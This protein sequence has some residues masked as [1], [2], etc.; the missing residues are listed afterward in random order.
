M[1]AQRFIVSADSHIIEPYD[2]WTKTLGKKHGDKVPQRVK[3]ARSQKG[4]IVKGDFVFTGHD[5]LGIGDL[6]QENAGDTLDSTAPVPTDDLPPELV[7]RVKRS[8]SD[9]AVRLAIQDYD[10]VAAEVIQGTN[11]LLAMRIRETAVLQDVAAVANDF[12]AD[13][14][15]LNPKRLIGTVMIPLR[16]VDWACKELVRNAKRGMRAAIINADMPAGF[17]PYRKSMYDKFWATAVE[18]DMVVVLHLG[19]GETVDPFCLVTPEE[20]EDGPKLFLDIFDD[21][22]RTLVNEF[23]FGGIFDR[24]PKLRVMLGE[25]ECSWFPYFIYRCRQMSGALGLAMR[26]PRVQRLADDYLRDNVWV[27]FTDDQYVGRTWDVAGEDKLMW[28]SD[29]P[30]PRNTFPNSRTIIDRI[31][32]DMPAHVK[33]NV[34]GL[35]CARLF[36]IDVPKLRA[37]AE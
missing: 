10:G 18:H 23:M 36:G 30:H 26:L 32:K 7:D 3:E 22:K 19:T 21:H 16:N 12:V 27:G 34:E 25:Y 33:A 6:R 31:C 17:P 2:L 29:Y 4:E 8:N 9:P 37:A 14:C 24:F 5:Y 28:G 35:N 13:Y 15:S 1:A 20:Q 11:M